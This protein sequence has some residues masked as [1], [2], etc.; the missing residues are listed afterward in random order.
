MSKQATMKQ[1]YDPSKAREILK[2]PSTP[3]KTAIEDC[4]SWWKANE[5]VK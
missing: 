5:Y 1:C 3:I 2:M 4:L